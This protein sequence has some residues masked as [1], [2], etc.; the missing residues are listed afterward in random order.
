MYFLCL[1]NSFFPF[2]MFLLNT[3]LPLFVLLYEFTIHFLSLF[4]S[5][6]VVCLVDTSNNISSL[7]NT[8]LNS[9]KVS[10]HM[11]LDFSSES[12]ILNQRHFCSFVHVYCVSFRKT[13]RKG[14]IMK[15]Q[16]KNHNYR[17][18]LLNIIKIHFS[19]NYC[20]HNNII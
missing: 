2:I 19:A 10:L 3:F 9:L 15:K 11:L 7:N 20:L 12:F 1:K 17:L 16:N 13:R 8:F 6:V 18:L 4:L 14:D 5:F